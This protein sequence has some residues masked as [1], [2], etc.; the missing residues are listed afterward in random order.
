MSEPK[1][2]VVPQAVA[3]PEKGGA[4]LKALLAQSRRKK[5]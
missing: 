5:K 2:E 1:P 3:A 4:D